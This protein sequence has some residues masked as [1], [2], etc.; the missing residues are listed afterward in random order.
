MSEPESEPG[1][2]DGIDDPNP[3]PAS[4]GAH[5]PAGEMPPG[6]EPEPEPQEKPFNWYGLRN[7]TLEANPEQIKKELDPDAGARAH[8][9]TGVCKQA[10]ASGIEAWMH[11]ALALYLFVDPE[12]SLLEPSESPDNIDTDAETPRGD[13][14]GNIE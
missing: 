13:R 8:A 9:V 12:G 10:G 1:P 2:F 3:D 5:G 14:W 6:P 7:S 4:D 11:Y